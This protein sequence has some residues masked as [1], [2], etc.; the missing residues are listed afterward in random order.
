MSSGK[1]RI[2]AALLLIGLLGQP[3][4]DAQ[5]RKIRIHHPHPHDYQPFPGTPFPDVTYQG[6]TLLA[7]ASYWMVY[8]SSYW[9]SGLGLAQ[10]KHFN[11]FVQ[12]VAPS[13]GFTNM[14]AE[15]EKPQYPILAGSWAGEKVITQG[16]PTTTVDDSGIVAQ[17]NQWITSSVLPVP[18]ANTVYVI[19]TGGGVDVTS[20][21]FSA[22]DPD[23]GFFGY[24]YAANS[25]SGSFGRYRYIV[26]PY[27]NCGSDLAP[28]ARSQ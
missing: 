22:C 10:R 11:T 14:F 20:D 6:G 27:Q 23:N 25:P 15:Y 18:D 3:P 19:F 21:G 8:W 12:T 7:H 28:M 24:H 5:I 16:A 17:I 2:A 26:M 13:A 4:A 9:T 1:F